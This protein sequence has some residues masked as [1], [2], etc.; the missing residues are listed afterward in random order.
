MEDLA[1]LL[2]S[3]ETKRVKLRITAVKKHSSEM[4]IEETE[5]EELS[6]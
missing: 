5:D 2:L 3:H 4:E 1:D 6:I